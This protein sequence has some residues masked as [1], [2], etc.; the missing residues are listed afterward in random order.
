MSR[1]PSFMETVANEL[2][3]STDNFKLPIF[4]VRAFEPSSNRLPEVLYWIVSS[5]LDS[6][7][8][9]LDFDTALERHVCQRNFGLES[10]A[11]QLILCVTLDNFLDLLRSNSTLVEAHCL[12]VRIF[13]D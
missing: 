2:G 12:F 7:E 13:Y 6:G 8:Y 4:L 10:Q 9:L 11:F 1:I 5:R 3:S